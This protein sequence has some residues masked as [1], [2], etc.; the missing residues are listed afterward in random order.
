MSSI[1]PPRDSLVNGARQNQVLNTIGAC[2][3]SPNETSRPQTFFFPPLLSL[4]LLGQK[5]SPHL[6]W[7]KLRPRLRMKFGAG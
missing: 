3:F 4:D 5:P 6:K 2:L 1:R 7:G